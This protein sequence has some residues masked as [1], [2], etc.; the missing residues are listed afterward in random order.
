MEKTTTNTLL[1]KVTLALGYRVGQIRTT[2][3]YI[4]GQKL[5]LIKNSYNSDPLG[6]RK[7][8]KLMQ[9]K[10]LNMYLWKFQVTLWIKIESQV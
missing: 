9:R 2:G 6:L 3:I 4:N 5:I 8:F 7:I 1:A 10:M